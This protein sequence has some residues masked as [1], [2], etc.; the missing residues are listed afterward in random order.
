IDAAK[1]EQW[2]NEEVVKL[3]NGNHPLSATDLDAAAA[4]LKQ[5]ALAERFERFLTLP[6]YGL[7]L[8]R[9]RG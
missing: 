6:A 5:L 1:V 3:K 2:L 7:L 4:I 8:Q 9:E